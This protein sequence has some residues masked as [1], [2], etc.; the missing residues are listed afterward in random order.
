M[1]SKILS[2]RDIDFLLYEWLDAESLTKRAR[3]ADHSRET[4]TAAMDT[5]EKVATDL[6]APHNKKSDQ[7]EPHFDGETVHIIPEVKAALKV[8]C[9][10]G[11][12][13]AGQDYEYGGMQLPVLI[14]KASFAYFKAANVGTSSYPFLT[15][16]N[17]NTLLKCGTPEQIDTFVKP[18]LEGRFFGTMCL[19]EP[20]AGSSLSD[21]VTRA[22]P[23]E[24]GTY[25]LKGNKMWISAGEHELSENIVHLV[26]AKVPD[27]NGKLIPGVKGISLFIVPKKL[28]NA[29]GSL[30]E[31]N[32]V[33][34]A[35][36]N[37]KMGYRGTTNCLL[38]FGEGKFKPGGKAG[39]VGYL[40]GEKHKGLANMFHMMNEA[41]IGV[42]L[43]A[44]VLGYTGYLHALE[45]ARERP[46]GRHP[47]AKDPAQPQIPIVQHTDVKRMLLAQK[48]YVEG[49]LALNLYCARLVD[50]EKT[51]ESEDAKRH[52]SLL[53]DILTPIAKSWPSQWCLEANS[54]AIQVHGGYGYTREYNVEQFYRDN[55]LNPIHE[56]THGIQGLDL[57]GRKVSMQNGAAFK[58]FGDEVQK[59]IAKAS[60]VPELAAYAQSL[61][62][63]LQRIAK[64]TQAL[65]AAGDMNKTLANASVYL[66]AFGHAVVAWMWLQQA[67]VAV[68]KS[69]HDADFYKGKLQACAYFFKWELPKVQP[70]LDLLESIDTTT[71]DMQDAWF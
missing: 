36:L 56:G 38:N 2:R 17:A 54:L 26:L 39:A 60:E 45:Y 35:G 68:G 29:D 66:E 46:Q 41:R 32:D 1:Q 49:G 69:G 71:L 22:E 58:A 11:L 48:S 20:Q 59:T 40:V 65:Y 21:I 62:A 70:Q 52:A 61:A 16:G 64:V 12:M 10:A 51:A 3:Y 33:V 44:V 28:V 23:Q 9:D 15:I 55:R 18:M 34:L 43:G 67:M 50:E 57:L 30:G 37:H 7:Q 19:S 31:R 5:C 8:F 25:R 27:E 53:L 13:A 47:M 24:D 4:F 14:E 6:F 42:G 63:V